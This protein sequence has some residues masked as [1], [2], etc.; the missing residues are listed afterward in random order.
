MEGNIKHIY[1][2]FKKRTTIFVNIKQLSFSHNYKCG[3]ITYHHQLSSNMW[4]ITLFSTNSFTQNS[5]SIQTKN[6]ITLSST[7]L[8]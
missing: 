8:K 5:N 1:G 2:I 3:G 7:S 6:D 4:G